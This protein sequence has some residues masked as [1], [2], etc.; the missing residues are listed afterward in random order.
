VFI[1]SS[2]NDLFPENQARLNVGYIG[3]ISN[4]RDIRHSIRNPELVRPYKNVVDESTN[5]LN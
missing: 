2:K 5:I 3:S 1:V 4:L